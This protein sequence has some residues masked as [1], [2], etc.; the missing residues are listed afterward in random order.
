MSTLLL[1]P[2]AED[3]ILAAS[4]WY[5]TCAPG[6]GSEF[7]RAVDD[8][9]LAI[10]ERP[11]QYPA[12]HRD[13]RRALVRRFPYGIFFVVRD[14]TVRAIGCLHIRRHPRVWHG[15]TDEGAHR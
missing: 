13:V 14:D 15:R 2:R 4:R 10:V 1:V 11:E 6:L 5:E 3:D 7:L 9:L 12:V 8:S